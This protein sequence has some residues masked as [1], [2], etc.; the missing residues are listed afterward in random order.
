MTGPR[1]IEIVGGG[2]AGLAAG[3]ALR[4]AGV[5]VT[6]YEARGYPRHRVCGEFISGLDGATSE[7][8]GLGEFL[9][10]A[11][12]HRGVTYHVHGRPLRPLE[13]PRVAWGISRRTLDARVA[14]AFVGAGGDLRT[15]TRAPGEEAKPGRVLANG[16]ARRG[17][18]WVGLKVHA[19]NLPLVN[20]F[21]IHLGDRAYVGLSRV[22]SSAVNLCGIFQMRQVPGRGAGLV[23]DY[24]RACGLAELADRVAAAD[25]D[26]QSFCACAATIRDAKLGGADAVRIGD[27]M[28]TIPPFTGN[29]LAMALQGAALALPHLG[30]YAAGEIAWEECARRTAAAQRRRF[31]R[32]LLVAR[33][34]HPLLLERRGQ[35]LLAHLLD[36]RLLPFRAFYAALS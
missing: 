33:L 14:R 1:H 26:P 2:L 10:D 25:A 19:Y 6:V 7:S 28:A 34:I 29:G 36:A 3:L 23:L 15:Q 24:L 35:A 32:R 11:L 9:A 18:F 30:A 8:L 22:E 17:P 16:R 4:R 21:E 20:D 31:R 13:L 5:P 27:A 12:P